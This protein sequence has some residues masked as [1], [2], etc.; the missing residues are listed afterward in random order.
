[1]ELCEK[2]VTNLGPIADFQKDYHVE[3]YAKTSLLYQLIFELIL[4]MK[5]SHR[6]SIEQALLSE[7]VLL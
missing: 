6:K 7:V 3:A 1:M 2:S 4:L 5:A